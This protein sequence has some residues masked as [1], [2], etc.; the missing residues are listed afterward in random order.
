MRGME[1]Q[2]NISRFTVIEGGHSPRRELQT[3]SGDERIT[4]QC[5]L[6]NEGIDTTEFMPVTTMLMRKGN[7]LKQIITRFLCLNCFLKG[8]KTYLN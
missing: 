1:I 8:R 7:E 2:S 4:C 6:F 3:R 5:C